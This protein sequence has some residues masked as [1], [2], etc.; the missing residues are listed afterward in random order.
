M[1]TN[2]EN[3]ADVETRIALAMSGINL[4]VAIGLAFIYSKKNEKSA[5]F[6]CNIM[7]KDPVDQELV[8][9]EI[10]SAFRIGR[11]CSRVMALSGATLILGCLWAQNSKKIL[12]KDSAPQEPNSN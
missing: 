5:Y 4:S 11:N 8:N 10:R 3:L 7:K 12:E 2:H 6:L 1:T 9:K